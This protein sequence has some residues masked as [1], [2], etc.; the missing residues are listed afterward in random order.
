VDAIADLEAVYGRFT[1]GLDRPDLCNARSMLARCHAEAARSRDIHQGSNG[2][3]SNGQGSNGLGSNGLGS[4]GQGSDG[5][6]SDGLGSDGLGSNG[7]RSNGL[8]GC[9]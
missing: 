8:G 7:L 2:L 3:G 9:G 4:N 5:L 6:R 1:E